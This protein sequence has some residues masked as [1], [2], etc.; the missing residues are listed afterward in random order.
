MRQV[1]PIQDTR[2]RLMLQQQRVMAQNAIIPPQQQKQ[3]VFSQGLRHPVPQQ[4]GPRSS[5]NP[6][7]PQQNQQGLLFLTALVVFNNQPFYK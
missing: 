4:L 1:A 5:M 7:D 2:M 6:Y 3:V